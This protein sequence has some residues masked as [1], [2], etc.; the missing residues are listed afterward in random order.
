VIDSSRFRSPVGGKRGIVDTAAVAAFAFYDKETGMS[1]ASH[2]TSTTVITRRAA[3]ATTVGAAGVTVLAACTGGGEGASSG[4]KNSS[5]ANAA[6]GIPLSEIPVGGAISATYKGGPI[7]IAQPESGTVV[8]FSA[9]CTHM[10]CVV[11]PAGKQFDCPCHGSEF[12][13]KTGDV[14]RGP[15]STPLPKLTA[16]VSGGKVTISS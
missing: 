4:S 16:T 11:A 9:I 7:L 8:A 12:S 1:G 15:A 14:L 6:D 5:K 13:A 2:D 10:G 3:L